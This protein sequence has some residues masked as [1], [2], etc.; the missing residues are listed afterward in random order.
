MYQISKERAIDVLSIC[1]IRHE[2]TTCNCI[3]CECYGK[4][5]IE[6]HR[7]AESAVRVLKVK[8]VTDG[9]KETGSTF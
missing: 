9:R 1:L 5:C 2:S 3:G 8:E 4:D 6:A 7:Y